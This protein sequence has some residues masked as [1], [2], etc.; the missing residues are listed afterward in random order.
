MVDY[1]DIITIEPKKGGSK[2]FIRGMSTTV[3]DILGW[4]SIGMSH[5]EIFEDFPEITE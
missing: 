2:P 5:E 4:L 3:G 1:T